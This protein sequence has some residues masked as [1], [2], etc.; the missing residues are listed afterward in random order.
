MAQNAE[1][2]T[3]RKALGPGVPDPKR[4]K[5]QNP[6]AERVRQARVSQALIPIEAGFTK[7]QARQPSPSAPT[8]TE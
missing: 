5:A 6:W 1:A 7:A 4:S 8:W 2:G 3:R